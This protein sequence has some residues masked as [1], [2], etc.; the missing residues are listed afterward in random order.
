MFFKS[1][2]SKSLKLW[3]NLGSSS[4]STRIDLGLKLET[5]EEN[6]EMKVK[7]VH[8]QIAHCKSLL[9]S[10]AEK[11]QSIFPTVLVYDTIRGALIS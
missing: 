11:N 7:N 5:T 2:I 10:V 3:T 4:Q 6:E 8:I 9:F 1:Y